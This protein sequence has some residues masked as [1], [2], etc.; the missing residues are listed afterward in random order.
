MKI[1]ISPAKSL[2]FESK[3]PAND[4]SNIPF[5]E[6][7]KELSQKMDLKSKDDLKKLMNISDQ[8]AELNYQRFQDFSFPFTKENARQ[9]VYS[10]SG[11]VY[12]GLDVYTLSEEHI[13]SMQNSL[14]ILSG[15]Y[16]LLKP[17]DLIQ[18][19]RLEMGTSLKVNSS[20]NLYEFWGSSITDYLNQEM[21]KE[22]IL[23]NLASKEYFK[24][25]QSKNLKATLVT[26]IFKDYKNGKLKIIS[27]FAKKARGQMAR[28]ILDN[29]IETL[30]E[31]R[32]FDIDGYGF[33][34]TETVHTYEPVF[35][36]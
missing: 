4:F 16:G 33:S 17:L 10:F 28:Y 15:L 13:D 23:V 18:P 35:I 31:L 3:I 7:T 14:R 2:D 22:E 9:A 27:F 26:P 24:A 36:R 20:N 6:Q 19:Y 29:G 5:L 32:G 34:K 25:V 1:L 8:L 12:K 21:G 11:D 30:E